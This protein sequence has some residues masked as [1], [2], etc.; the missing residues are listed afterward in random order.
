MKQRASAVTPSALDR[1]FSKRVAAA[2][3]RGDVAEGEPV[4]DAPE[5]APGIAARDPM[6]ENAPHASALAWPPV[7]VA[8]EDGLVVAVGA[9]VA[10]FSPGDAAGLQAIR[11]TVT[12]RK[13]AP[14]THRRILTMPPPFLCR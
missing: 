11:P 1:E 10:V 14:P 9:A 6:N 2:P 7:C 12:T 8:V 13:S 5:E 3:A 4:T